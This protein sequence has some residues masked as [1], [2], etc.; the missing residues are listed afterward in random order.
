MA[1]FTFLNV[2]TTKIF[3]IP[4]GPY[5]HSHTD[6]WMHRESEQ[7]RQARAWLAAVLKEDKRP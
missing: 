4:E 7:R 5:I 3:K 6:L 2:P 1:E